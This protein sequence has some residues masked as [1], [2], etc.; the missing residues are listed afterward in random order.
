MI[1][2]KSNQLWVYI[3]VSRHWNG[4]YWGWSCQVGESS[5]EKF[6]GTGNSRRSATRRAKRH[7]RRF[8]KN[9]TIVKI[10]TEEFDP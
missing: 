7:A 3:A 6:T 4:D 5:E 10:T 2:L 8:V 1:E 9:M